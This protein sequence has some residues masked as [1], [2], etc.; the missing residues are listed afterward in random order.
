MS[1][2]GAEEGRVI[3]RIGLR[4]ADAAFGRGGDMNRNYSPG[5]R[6][7]LCSCAIMATRTHAGRRRVDIGGTEERRVIAGIACSMTSIAGCIGCH[8]RRRFPFGGSPVMAGRAHAYRCGM[9]INDSEEGRVIGSVALGMAA[10][11]VASRTRRYVINGFT[12]GLYTVMACRAHPGRVA[13]SVNRPE[14]SRVVA[15]I[16]LG[17]A[18]AACIRG[19]DVHRRLALCRGAVM[20]GGTDT[21]RRRV[22]EASPEE[23]RVVAGIDL[24][25]AGIALRSGQHMGWRFAK[26]VGKAAIVASRTPAIVGGRVTISYSRKRLVIV[27]VGLRM[28]GIALSRCRKMGHRLGCHPWCDA[29]TSIA[30]A[31]HGNRIGRVIK[32]RA[33]ESRVIIGIALGMAD[34]AG[35]CRDNMHC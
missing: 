7:A 22:S 4:M 2:C 20:A 30:Y 27:G 1:V 16:C 35:L 19:N 18:D 11:A 5:T 8:M 33:R 12:G 24:R 34:F 14:E 23:C 10:A 31:R 17:V 29:M 9:H 25:M 13:V 21:R 28:T 6:L 3:G 26:S 32:K 15:G